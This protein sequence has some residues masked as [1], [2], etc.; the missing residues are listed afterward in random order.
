MDNHLVIAKNTLFLYFRMLLTMFVSLYASR[1][2][3][4]V[5]GIND[6]GIF[7]TV[8][9]VVGLISFANNALSAGS[10]RYLTFA[11]GKGNLDELKKTFSSIFLIHLA[12]ALLVAIAA[13]TVG[14]WFVCHNAEI[15]PERID[16]AVFAYH[17]IV[18]SVFLSI[19]QIPYTACIISH[20]KMAVFAYISVIEAF[21]KL[22]VVY[23]LQ[24]G[25]FDKLKMYAVLLCIVQLGITFSYRLYCLKKLPESRSRFIVDEII[26]KNVL[27]YTGWNLLTNTASAVVLHGSTVMTNV[28]FNP[29]IVAARAIANQVNDS[30]NQVVHNFRN[31][32][33]PQIVKKFAAED[34]EGSKQLLLS[35]TKIS[36]YLM[37]FLCVPVFLETEM[38]LKIWLGFV[39]DYSAAFLRIAIV[40]SLIQVFSH[41]FYAALYAKGTIRENAIFTSIVN[42]VMFS[43]VYL[44]F[45][46]GFSPLALAWSIFIAELFL[47]VCVKSVLVV[48]IV[49]YRWNDIFA[50]YIPCI[51]V[52]L[53][54]IPIPLLVLLL[55]N[56]INMNEI[57][58]FVVMIFLSLASVFFSIWSIGLNTKQRIFLRQIAGKFVKRGRI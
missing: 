4:Q 16:A 53:V 12:L 18:V 37:L 50:V 24:I 52:F 29:S 7:Q 28:F 35:S 8:V 19:T 31:A 40:T 44:L 43:V 6:F 9:G 39:P 58:R 54:A 13:E 36:F 47:A 11:L 3:L 22:F 32:S 42:F 46:L 25:D 34:F 5:L 23:L 14:L 51:K 33:N 30:A 1:V 41:S 21:L 26:I 17:F 45:K 48:K 20:E 57:L 55:L 10:S 15:L 49:G 38:I 56:S 27:K 2:V